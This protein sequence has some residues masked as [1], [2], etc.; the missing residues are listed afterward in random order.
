MFGI[1]VARREFPELL[2]RQNRLQSRITRRS[3]EADE[4]VVF[5]ETARPR[6]L[7]VWKD[8]QLI[9]MPWGGW[10]FVEALRSGE[11]GGEE[12]EVP[13]TFVCD[14]GF[15]FAA[16]PIKAGIVRGKV[17]PLSQPASHYYEVMTRQKRMPLWVGETI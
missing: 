13:C 16:H 14:N 2:I 1:S 15:W 5:Y 7:P 3:A 10:R 11:W 9:V 12:A 8:G 4:E 17:F 6:V